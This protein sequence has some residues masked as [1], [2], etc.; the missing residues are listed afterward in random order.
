MTSSPTPPASPVSAQKSA[1]QATPD[2]HI[3]GLMSAMRELAAKPREKA[4][5]EQDIASAIIKLYEKKGEAGLQEFFQRI[6]SGGNPDKKEKAAMRASSADLRK[7]GDPLSRRA[8]LFSIGEIGTGASLALFL[9]VPYLLK[10][11]QTQSPIKEAFERQADARR[12]ELVEFIQQQ[13]EQDQVPPRTQVEAEE[14]KVLFEQMDK[15][16]AALNPAPPQPPAL[17]TTISMIVGITSLVMTDRS[18]R[19]AK[20]QLNDMYAQAARY[21]VHKAVDVMQQEARAHES[22]AMSGGIA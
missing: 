14:E 13:P 9:G 2:N 22:S 8:F 11:L 20:N 19:E 10:Y 15:R 5:P 4:L 12:R 16:I 1:E 18:R 17:A 3:A 7:E 6:Q 21:I